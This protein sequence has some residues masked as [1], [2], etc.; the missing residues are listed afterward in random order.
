MNI[1]GISNITNMFDDVVERLTV[2][3]KALD[4][5]KSV[6]G[7]DQKVDLGDTFTQRHS[8]ESLSGHIRTPVE[9]MGSAGRLFGMAL[10]RLGLGYAT[11]DDWNKKFSNAVDVLK[12]NFDLL[13]TAAGVGSK[14]GFIGKIDLEAALKNPDMPK[15]VKD[16]CRFLLENPSA[17]NQ[18]DVGAGIGNCDG[19]IAKCD[20]D[21]VS[22]KL[23]EKAA[24]IED[25]S[26]ADKPDEVDKTGEPDKESTIG[27][28]KPTK[29]TE[30]T[31]GEN[32]TEE[33]AARE[34]SG[35]TENRTDE[36]R[37]AGMAPEDV[38]QMLMFEMMGSLDDAMVDVAKDLKEANDR[39]INQD[40]NS[41]DG[42]KTQLDIN[43]LQL[44]LQKLMEQRKMMFEMIS[45]MSRLH[46]EMAKSALSNMGRA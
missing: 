43:K 40:S 19:I 23:A 42:K 39:L 3:K 18:L 24:A 31:S 44:Q 36:S 9:W 20:V 22:A 17:W 46:H 33:T 21:A 11:S 10:E 28:T 38:V 45:T 6:V 30:E 37:F 32:K 41:K 16:A 13:D 8:A 12:N 4:Q 14:D 25:T 7:G 29:E 2:N 15:E 1:P 34:D 5:I 26:K 35:K 27:D